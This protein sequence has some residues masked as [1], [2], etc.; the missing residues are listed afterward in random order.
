MSVTAECFCNAGFGIANFS[1][2][3][4]TYLNYSSNNFKLV[5]EARELQKCC[6]SSCSYIKSVSYL[7]QG[8]PPGAFVQPVLQWHPGDLI[9]YYPE[10]QRG[11]K[12]GSCIL[13]GR[14][15]WSIPRVD[16]QITTDDALSNYVLCIHKQEQQL[17]D[18]QYPSRFS[19]NGAV[20]HGHTARGS[21][22]KRGKNDRGGSFKWVDTCLSNE[23]HPCLKKS[24]IYLLFR[25]FL[26][27]SS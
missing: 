4:Q 22:E 3:L 8:S 26:L 17:P 19:P 27:W 14:L 7:G 23:Q 2:L 12:K 13:M 21:K 25:S 9:F 10:K 20:S 18:C 5:C 16:V 1:H 11:E 24:E 15:P 6:F